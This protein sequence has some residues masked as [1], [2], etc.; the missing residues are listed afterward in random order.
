[1]SL[2]SCD[3]PGVKPC[4]PLTFHWKKMGGM[5]SCRVML[6]PGPGHCRGQSNYRGISLLN[7]VGKD[8]GH[9]EPSTRQ[10]LTESIYIP[11][12]YVVSQLVW[13]S[14]DI[15]MR[16]AEKRDKNVCCLHRQHSILRAGW[17]YSKSGSFVLWDSPRISSHFMQIWRASYIL[18][19]LIQKLSI[20]DV[21]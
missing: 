4:W 20:S 19:A 17:S 2:N 7:I 6:K 16:N 15:H 3:D 9:V 12:W 1:M 8:F 13:S 11:V 14:F 21:V 18:A 5:E 10:K